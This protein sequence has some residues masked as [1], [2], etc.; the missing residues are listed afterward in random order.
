MTQNRNT[1][2]KELIIWVKFTYPTQREPQYSVVNQ[3]PKPLND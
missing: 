2:R 1:P 3:K